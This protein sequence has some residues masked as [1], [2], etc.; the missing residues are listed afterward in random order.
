MRRW[1][2]AGALIEDPDGNVLMVCNQRRDGTQDWSTPGGVIEDGEEVLAGLAREVVEETGIVVH[3][4]AGPAYTVEIEAPDLGWI[5]RVE[6]H[7]AVR[8]TGAVAIDD[9][10][11][12]VIDAFFVPRDD[13]QHQLFGGARWVAEPL[14]AWLSGQHDPH[15]AYVAL[16]TERG[17]LSVTR[18]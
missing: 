17:S 9:P 2:V 16:G 12:I 7:R 10:D 15:Y 11:G 5:L 8:W 6:A 13:C 14:L 1:Y 18:R 4:W 3:E